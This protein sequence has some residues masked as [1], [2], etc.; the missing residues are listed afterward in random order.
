MQLHNIEQRT[1]AWFELRKA[2]PLTASN[3]QAIATGGKGLETLAW[4]A[5]TAKYRL[6]PAEGYTNGHMER[7]VELEATAREFYE[8]ITL[9]S[10]EE[11]GFVTNSKYPLAG[12][13]PDGFAGDGLVEIK[14]FDDTKFFRLYA[15]SKHSDFE[16]E[17]K[18]MW[19]MQMQMLVTGRKW[20]DYVIF[21]ENFETPIILQRV[22]KDEEKQAKIVEGLQK[23][24]ELL[25]KIEK[26]LHAS[27]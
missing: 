16:V 4:E 18:Y 11:V 21:N 27:K 24:L 25:N 13:S 20:C 6:T 23:G 1:E 2:H 26:D 10:V 15:Q 9:Q 14:C 17:S 12:A 19:Q 5:V 22:E 8:A 3:A 7:G